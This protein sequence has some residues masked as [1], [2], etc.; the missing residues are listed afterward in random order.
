MVNVTWLGHACF[1]LEDGGKSLVFDPFRDIGL[2][3]PRVKADIVLCSHSHS[4]H[5]N[6]RAVRHERSI[7][8]EGFGG[9]K[10]VDGISIRGINTFHDGARGAA[11]GK[12]TVYIVG[13]GGVTFC[14][15]GDL[16]HIL[17]PSQIGDV[18]PVHVLFLPIGG[19]YTIGPEEAR[20]VME[21]LG[22]KVT[23]PMHYRVQGMSSIFDPLSVL[24]DFIR[25]ED[26]VS[27]LDGPSFT[28]VKMDLPEKP[29]I[30]VPK[31]G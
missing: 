25:R 8:L 14:H 6:V 26:N 7:V 4:D 9:V 31:L 5:N 30:I 22:P 24:E 17:T 15:M 19:Y 12:N 13:F 16:G 27:R 18:G 21:S 3:E 11:R 29:V 2:P 10:E 20:K 28:V 1:M 23:V